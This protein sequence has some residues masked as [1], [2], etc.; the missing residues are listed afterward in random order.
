[1]NFGSA[2]AELAVCV[3]AVGLVDRSELSK[4]VLEAPP[5][6][7]AALTSRLVGDAVVP[8]RRAVRRQ[9]V[10][11]RR[12]AGTR[13]RAVRPGHRVA[14][15]R[16]PACGRPSVRDD[17]RARRLR[18]AGRDRAARPRART[19]CCARSER[20][21]SPATRARCAPF[22]HG[23]IA[24]IPASWLLQSDRRALALVP[25]E[26]AGE[27]WLAIERAG[28]PFGI[29]CVGHEA[30]CRYAL[31]ERTR[32]ARVPARLSVSGARYEPGRRLTWRPSSACW[33]SCSRSS[34]RSSRPTTC[35]GPMR[36]SGWRTPSGGSARS[37]RRR[38][39][40]TAPPRSS[41][42][43]RRSTG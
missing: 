6:Q 8:W 26:H 28:R 7:L 16:P 41:G 17:D 13:D 14:A 18:R 36:S 31:L 19:R 15:A 30:A 42:R 25:R 9:R 22:A 10:V 3:R 1:M 21:A 37:A 33:S 11:V 20:S 5:A 23:Q 43:A 24:G 27:A 12:R 2:A 38:E 40:S 39:S 32:P 35:G 34:A 4:L 29:S